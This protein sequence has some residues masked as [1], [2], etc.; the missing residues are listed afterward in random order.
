[1]ATD[2]EGDQQHGQV[3]ERPVKYAGQWVAR[4]E[5]VQS[6][7]DHYRCLPGFQGQR[8]LGDGPMGLQAG[9]VHGHEHR[10]NE[11]DDHGHHHALQVESVP[12]VGTA[13]GDLSRCIQKGVEGFVEGI[14][15]FQR[16]A[17]VEVPGL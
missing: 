7:V 2:Q 1:M 17:L 5:P 8:S 6:Q 12:D 9:V 16:S 10:G 13:L 11:S 4:V 15:E 3:V 14:G